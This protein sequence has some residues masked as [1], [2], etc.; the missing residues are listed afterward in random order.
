[1]VCCLVHCQC[2]P[3]AKGGGRLA[4]DRTSSKAAAS[5]CGK[6]QGAVRI[7]ANK[8][9]ICFAKD[10]RRRSVLEGR[11]FGLVRHCDLRV[12][13]GRFEVSCLV[14]TQALARASFSMPVVQSDRVGKLDRR[15]SP[16]CI[17]LWPVW[18][19]RPV[20]NMS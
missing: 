13:G 12:R 16:K 5:A 2:F 15:S 4:C 19:L 11:L 8:A 18:V 10:A 20:R 14:R 1:M 6:G 9:T 7:A 3:W 17:V